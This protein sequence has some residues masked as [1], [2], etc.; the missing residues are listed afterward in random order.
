MIGTL[1][2]VMVGPILWAAHLMLIYGSQ[3]SLCAFEVGLGLGGNSPLAAGAVLGGTVLCMV[4]SGEALAKPEATFGL[5]TGIAEPGNQWHFLRAVM[6]MLTGL[7]LLAMLYAG[8]GAVLLPA[9]A[10][11]R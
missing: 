10:Q 11:L 5:I 7:S 1:V 9:C 2:F 4:L 6:R 3:S 8:L